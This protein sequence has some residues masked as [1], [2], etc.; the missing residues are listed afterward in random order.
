MNGK[1]PISIG[2][3]TIPGIHN[4]T[5][6]LHKNDMTELSE[7]ISGRLPKTIAALIK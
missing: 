6:A 5:D 4:L 1:E 2:Y 7:K 3:P